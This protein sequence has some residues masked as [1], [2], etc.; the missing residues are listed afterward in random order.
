MEVEEMI[1]LYA[2]RHGV[3]KEKAERVLVT[4]AYEELEVVKRPTQIFL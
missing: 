2:Q 1:E 4:Y 3:T